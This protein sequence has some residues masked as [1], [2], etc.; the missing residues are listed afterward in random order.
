[1]RRKATIIGILAI[2]LTAAT[3]GSSP[4]YKRAV[5][6]VRSFQRSFG[7]LQKADSMSPIERFVF[8]LVLS[9]SKTPTAAANSYA[10]RVG[11]T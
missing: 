11:R 3:T 6:S 5:S 1:M 8:S 7:D 4:A 10:P 9:N 2:L